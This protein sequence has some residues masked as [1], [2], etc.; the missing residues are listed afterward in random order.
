MT[1]NPY[2]SSI[3]FNPLTIILGSLFILVIPFLIW[4]KDAYLEQ[5]SHA[6]GSVIASAK[7]QSIQ[8]AIDGVITKVS[9]SEGEKVNEGQ[10]LVLLNKQQ[11]LAAF[12]PSLIKAKSL[13]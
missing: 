1:N 11:N 4:S 8:T 10:E 13:G 12:C 6:T 9:V 5:I 3:L 7:T 2:N